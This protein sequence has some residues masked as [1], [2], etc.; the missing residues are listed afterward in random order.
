MR[1]IG[2]DAANAWLETHAFPNNHGFD[3]VIRP[4]GN[5]DEYYFSKSIFNQIKF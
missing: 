4:A 3:H 5:F 1:G 2:D